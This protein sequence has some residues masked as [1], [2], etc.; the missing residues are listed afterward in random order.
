M[1]KVFVW[2][3]NTSLFS[4]CSNL[5]QKQSGYIECDWYSWF[6]VPGTK[7]NFTRHGQRCLSFG[8]E[9]WQRQCFKKRFE[10]SLKFNGVMW[11][12]NLLF[13]RLYEI[14]RSLKFAI[15]LNWA[16]R[17]MGPSC[18]P[19]IPCWWWFA[20]RIFWTCFFQHLIASHLTWETIVGLRGDLCKSCFP[21]TL[22]VRSPK[23]TNNWWRKTWQ[24]SAR[25]RNI[26]LTTSLDVGL[27]IF[28]GELVHSNWFWWPIIISIWHAAYINM[29]I[30]TPV[31]QENRSNTTK[32]FGCTFLR[33][34]ALPH[35]QVAF[36]KWCRVM[37]YVCSKS[38]GYIIW[39]V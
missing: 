25:Y 23:K 11:C 4:R 21:V 16:F 30:E 6:F 26:F 3:R 20:T 5:S 35:I 18:F 10:M 31:L 27:A 38:T 12:A 2:W 33:T 19:S 34:T 37:A 29:I 7:R 15:S 39:L 17:S 24:W 32:T 14:H 22:A 28:G 13:I 36:F 8:L 1:C 9:F